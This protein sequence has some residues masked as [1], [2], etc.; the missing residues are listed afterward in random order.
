MPN[1]LSKED[2]SLILKAAQSV[3]I[4]PSKLSVRN[5]FDPS[6]DGPV[7]NM[8]REAIRQID[9]QRASQMIQSAGIGLSLKAQAVCE[10]LAEMDQ[11]VWEE[12][13]QKDPGF[14]ANQRAAADA[15]L[16]AS[17][18]KQAEEAVAFGEKQ[19]QQLQRK[20]PNESTGQHNAA[21]LRRVGVQNA[22]QLDR[23]PA[24]RLIP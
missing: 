19:R 24:R 7:P 14:V 20:A 16:L 12:I 5:P 17:L 3:K 18:E 23:I 9:P 10:G 11:E 1:D 8:L 6:L 4:D 22:R 2:L 21:F 15:R 13:Q